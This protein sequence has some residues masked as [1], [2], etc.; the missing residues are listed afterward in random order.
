MTTRR[1][2]LLKR[3][4]LSIIFVLGARAVAVGAPINTN[5]INVYNAF[6]TGATVQ[7]FENV[8]GMWPSAA[9]CG[10]EF[11]SARGMPASRVGIVR[12]SNTRGFRLVTNPIGRCPLDAALYLCLRLR[13]AS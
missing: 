10:S 6:A 7:T 3:M 8:S 1:A 11:V 9:A 5:D 2:R 4:G 12:L 13:P